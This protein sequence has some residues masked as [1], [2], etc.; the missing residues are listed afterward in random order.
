MKA[1]KYLYTCLALSILF[2]AACKTDNF[3]APKSKLT[4]RIIY[5]NEQIPVRS[6]GVQLELW[7]RGYQLFTKIPVHVAQDGTFSAE[8]FDGNYNLVLLRGNGP[9]VDNTDSIKVTVKGNTNIDM[10]VNPYF[11]IKNLTAAKNGNAINATFNIEHINTTKT[12]ERVRL[13]ISKTNIL[14]NV[15]NDGNVEILAAN[16]A[17]ITQPI[18]L[19]INIPSALTSKDYVFVRVGVKT[20]GVGEYIFS[21]P[22]QISI[23]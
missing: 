13:F 4:G 1:I 22:Q 20:N 19:S 9:W 2:M 18:S 16:I 11:I 6:N 14:D 17:N 15:N 23:K 7:Q 3:D 5:N 10:P 8:L 21:Q 12:L